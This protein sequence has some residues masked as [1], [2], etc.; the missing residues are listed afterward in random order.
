MINLSLGLS[1]FMIAGLYTL[2]ILQIPILG[3]GDPLGPRLLP[4]LLAGAMVLIGIALVIEGLKQRDLR[5]GIA[6]LADY[7]RDRDFRVT[8]IVV[9]WTAL[10]FAVFTTVGYL[11]A[12]AV[13]LLGLILAFHRGSRIAGATVSVAFAV[14]SYFLF[15]G[16]FGVPLPSGILFF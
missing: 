13:F 16:L 10:Y 8:V 11:V 5:T 12:T 1:A 4:G 6:R 9:A 14:G 7:F 3:F 2:G 15:A